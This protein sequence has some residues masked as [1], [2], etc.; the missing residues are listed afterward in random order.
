MSHNDLVESR[1]DARLT[2]ETLS[3][4]RGMDARGG[5][6]LSLYIGFDSSRMP[7]L[8]ERRME[9][10]SL[11]AEVERRYAGH[12]EVSHQSR[13]ALRE[14]VQAVRELLADDR[15][16]APESTHGL[17]SFCSAPAGICEIV[18]LAEPV[19]PMVVFDER[20]FLEPLVELSVP[21]RWCVLLI[22]R[23]ASRIFT[24][25]RERLIEVADVFDDVHSRHAQGGWSQARYERGIEQE[26]D[27]HIRAT[28]AALSKRF[29]RR[30][31]DSL[32]VA[33]PA[34][35]HNRVERE[36]HPQLRQQLAGY[37]EIDVERATPDE[38]RRRAMPLI[39]TEERHREHE[40]LRR[41]NEGL[42]PAGHAAAGLDEV[43]ELLNERRVQ[44]L[45]VAH[46]FAA[47]GFACPRCGRLSVGDSP[48]PVDGVT[49]E[50][51]QK[52]GASPIELALAGSAEVLVVR[53]EPGR[54]RR[55]RLDRR[56]AAV[57]GHCRTTW[58]DCPNL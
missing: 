22:S 36:L 2:S 37:F 45:L 38:V 28:C 27:E 32:L 55:P 6:V 33:G 19:D 25:T 26:I 17:A 8:R 9:L 57:L 53:H 54:A 44:T 58:R 1:R 10:D 52:I 42:A 13:M 20:P 16:L 47:Q 7:N 11:L 23:R 3:R 21:G 56:P 49:A 29:E 41:L 35:L 12:G 4:L 40:E 48:C 14:D 46:G 31:F 50:V 30:S 5:R 34:E 24:G 43:L 51:R 39:E 15:E 18:R